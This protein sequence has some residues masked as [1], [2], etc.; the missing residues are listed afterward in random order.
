MKGY[1]DSQFMSYG[2]VPQPRQCGGCGPPAPCNG[3]IGAYVPPK[4]LARPCNQMFCSGYPDEC[5]PSAGYEKKAPVPNMYAQECTNC[6][7]GVDSQQLFDSADCAS[8]CDGFDDVYVDFC[9]DVAYADTLHSD[10]TNVIST[11][12]N[13]STDIRGPV[14]CASGCSG[15]PE[16]QF[17]GL[18]GRMS[19]QPGD[20]WLGANIPTKGTHCISS[21]MPLRTFTY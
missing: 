12:Y 20:L 14:D 17:Q 21:N 8:G 9:R 11:T 10:Y 5:G 7:R 13:Q 18:Y 19:C 2:N 15:C 6:N 16:H 3:L 1:S 4:N